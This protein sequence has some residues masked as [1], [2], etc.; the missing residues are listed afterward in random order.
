MSDP[1]V[2]DAE[3]AKLAMRA[4][5]RSAFT[6]ARPEAQVLVIGVTGLMTPITEQLKQAWAETAEGARRQ[7]AAL[8]RWVLEFRKIEYQ[9][10]TG[11]DGVTRVIEHR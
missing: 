9:V 8:H 3:A 4:E 7:V 11:S 1:F 6:I 5:M 2:R 10:V